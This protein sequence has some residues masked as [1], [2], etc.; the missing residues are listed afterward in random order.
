V[1]ILRYLNCEI[2]FAQYIM[3]ALHIS[4]QIFSQV[5]SI[6]KYF[7]ETFCTSP[8]R[9]AN[10]SVGCTSTPHLTHCHSF[11]IMS[12]FFFFNIND[13]VSVL[14]YNV[15][16]TLIVMINFQ[17]QKMST[18]LSFEEINVFDLTW[19]VRMYLSTGLHCKIQKA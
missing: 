16:C 12:C 1:K 5:Q 18:L 14:S 10:L 15:Y 17:C 11:S 8:P 7:T 19:H 2:F 4:A 13:V 9:A 6:C 3:Y